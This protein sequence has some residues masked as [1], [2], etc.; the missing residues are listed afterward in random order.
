MKY[1]ACKDHLELI[2]NSKIMDL[3][4]LKSK[5]ENGL[6]YTQ[7]IGRQFLREISR[8]VFNKYYEGLMI[9][10][11]PDIAGAIKEFRNWGVSDI[12]FNFEDNFLYITLS[13]PG[14]IIGVKGKYIDDLRK[15]LKN[16]CLQYNFPFQGIRQYSPIVLFRLP[17]RFCHNHILCNC[18]RTP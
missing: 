14:L 7:A 18:H 16:W 2:K 15:H 6:T 5:M 11:D 10:E 17:S 9:D 12:E 8:F 13:R 3:R 4:E 1:D